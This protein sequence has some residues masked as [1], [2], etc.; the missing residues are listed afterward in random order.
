L[1]YKFVES[2]WRGEVLDQERPLDSCSALGAAAAANDLARGGEEI[3]ST[4]PWALD[5]MRRLI[6][7]ITE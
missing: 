6:P 3:T 1:A 4:T 2:E 5:G 7:I